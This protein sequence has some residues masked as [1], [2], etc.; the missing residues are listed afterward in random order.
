MQKS[1]WIAD[2]KQSPR[3][4]RIIRIPITV[5]TLCMILIHLKKKEKKLLAYVYNR[6]YT[7]IPQ[8][9]LTC[10]PWPPRSGWSWNR[11]RRRSRPT[12]RRGRRS[13]GPWV[14]GRRRGPARRTGC[15]RRRPARRA[16]AAAARL[17]ERRERWSLR[18]RKLPRISASWGWLSFFFFFFEWDESND[19]SR[20]L[21]IYRTCVYGKNKHYCV[22]VLCV[23]L[24]L[25]S[26]SDFCESEA[27]TTTTIVSVLT[28]RN[29]MLAFIPERERGPRTFL[30]FWWPP[31]DRPRLAY[32]FSP[33]GPADRAPHTHTRPCAH[34]CVSSSCRRCCW[35]SVGCVP[36][37]SRGPAEC[38]HTRKKESERE[39][40]R[41]RERDGRASL[42]PSSRP[43]FA[44]LTRL[45]SLSLFLSLSV[46]GEERRGDTSWVRPSAC[47]RVKGYLCGI[48][49]LSVG[50][51]VVLAPRPGLEFE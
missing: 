43:V 37:H 51:V 41:E 27:R 5:R 35:S 6:G 25:F 44:S 39:R 20:H 32:W 22:Y 14:S 16:M 3:V 29:T 30:K 50:D 33:L 23:C 47:E 17:P 13:R 42:F 21:A 8:R 4:N 26:S 40:E 31:P 15:T 11:Q 36:T 34:V 49:W 48:D 12:W 38:V 28:E 18:G 2:K 7:R 19:V 24:L 10:W 46:L 1:R 9:C 45:L